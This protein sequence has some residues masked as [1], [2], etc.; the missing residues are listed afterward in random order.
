M[1]YDITTI[2]KPLRIPEWEV[3]FESARAKLFGSADCS[4]ARFCNPQRWFFPFLAN[5]CNFYYMFDD[6]FFLFFMITD[7]SVW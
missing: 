2:F 5:L 7:M 3:P 1:T 6:M 4:I